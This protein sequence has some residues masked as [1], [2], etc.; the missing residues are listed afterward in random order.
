MFELANDSLVVEV[1]DPDLDRA[2][3]GVRY[4][5][6]GY[7]FQV[8]D[9]THGALMSGPTW[10]DEFNWFDGQGIPDAFNLG[11]LTSRTTP[12][13]AL[14]IGIG[15]CDLNARQVRTFCEWHVA[16]RPGGIA[17]TT[18]QQYEGRSFTLVRDVSLNGRT[19]RSRTTLAN[20]GRGEVPVRWFPHPFYPQPRTDELLWVNIPLHWRDGAGYTRC[21]NGF[22]ARTGWPWTDG[23]Y[24]PLDHDATMPLVLVQRHPKLGLVTAACSYVPDFFPIWGN[25]TTFSWEPFLERT[26]AAGQTLDWWIDYTF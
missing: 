16:R 8:H 24:L 2:R 7:V 4:C 9:R 20:D 5:T 14:V 6:G 21:G 17:F 13:E 11:P 23:H 12:G 19:L 25:R 26:V 10:P 1:L 18:A 3:F 22:I 15:V